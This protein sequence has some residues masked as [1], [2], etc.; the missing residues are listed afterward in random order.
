LDI[1]TDKYL[2]LLKLKIQS[3]PEEDNENIEQMT[4]Q[5]ISELNELEVD[6]VSIIKE[7]PLPNAKGDGALLEILITLLA[8]GG[9]A[10][11]FINFLQSWSKRFD[12]RTIKVTTEN[13]KIVELSG[14]S[15]EEAKQL[16][17]CIKNS[18][19]LKS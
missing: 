8:S 15:S 12:G 3:K 7:K 2:T 18:S 9:V 10:T 19:K 5:L 17:E 14:Y 11:N 4:L 1:D 13:G 6:K 16:I